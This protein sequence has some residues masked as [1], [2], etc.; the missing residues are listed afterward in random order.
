MVW[1]ERAVFLRECFCDVLTL[2]VWLF[3]VRL[4]FLPA[5][6]HPI[7]LQ[8]SL[9]QKIP[10]VMAPSCTSR[11]TCANWMHGSMLRRPI[12]RSY[13]D[14]AASA[15][16]G[17]STHLVVHWLLRSVRVNFVVGT[18]SLHTLHIALCV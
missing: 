3:A 13:K 4:S 1:A 17:F 18:A 10:S 12:A 6:H 11:S 8:V 15:A 7:I 2:W 16:A 9:T 14:V 5:T